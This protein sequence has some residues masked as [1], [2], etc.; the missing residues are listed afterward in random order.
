[1]PVFAFKGVNAAGK[2][3][4]GLLDAESSRSARGKLRK[5]GVFLTE[6]N[7]QRGVTSVKASTGRSFRLPIFSR[8]PP[9]ELAL[10]TRQAATLLSSGIPLVEGLTALTEQTE[11]V[12]LRGALGEARERV[13]EGSQLA[14]ALAQTGVFP[15]LYVSMVRAGEAGGALETVLERLADYLESQVRLRNK[16]SSILIYPSVMFGFAMLVVGV[17]V[18]VVLPQITELLTSLNQELPFYTRWVI[19]L[20]NFARVWWWAIGL[21]MLGIALGLRT[22]ISTERGRDVFDTLK[23]RLPVIGRTTRIIAIARFSRTLATLLAGGLPIVRSLDT[24]KHVANNTVLGRAIDAARVSITEGATVAAP[25]RNSGE[26]PPMVVHMIS[27]GERSGQLEMMLSKIADTYEEQ[28]ETTVTRMTA[29]L[30][31]L[32]ILLMVGI[33][34]V[35]ILATLVPLLQV[36]NSIA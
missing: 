36:T 2:S 19:G 20:S 17:L 6:L 4:N 22:A 28:V 25:L 32:L 23:L 9:L 34:V 33:V 15:D 26:F 13:N 30:E 16:V 29:L 21:S 35:I 14:D 12:R 8:V 1:M 3:I 31:P 11:N 18:T 10:A 27:I 5:D 24:A 7:E